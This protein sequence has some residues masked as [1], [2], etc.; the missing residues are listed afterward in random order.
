MDGRWVG[1]MYIHPNNLRGKH[2]NKLLSCEEN[3]NPDFI[4]NTLL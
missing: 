3:T 1:P 4:K 2:N